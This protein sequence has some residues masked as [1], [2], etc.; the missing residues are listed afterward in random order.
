M[1]SEQTR[2]VLALILPLL[3]IVVGLLPLVGVGTSMAVVSGSSQT[4]VVPASYAFP[5]MWT[6]LFAL[7]LAYGVWQILPM[8][9]AD[10]LLSRVGWPL[11]GVFALNTLWEA[12]AQFSGRN[13]FFLVAIMLLNVVC[14]LAAFFL[15]RRGVEPSRSGRWLVLP[16]TGLMAGWLTAACFANISGA[17]RVAGIIPVEGMVAT[18]A[19]VLLLLAAGGFAAA[20]VWAAKGSVWYLGG[21]GWALVAVVVANL[22]ANQ[23]DVLAALTAAVMLALVA[24]VAWTRRTPGPRGRRFGA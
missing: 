2:R 19:A 5:I 24:G 6:V 17:A 10:P 22:G 23:L 13:G 21:V 18:V 14:A 4:P 12:V 9:H 3:Q 11:V 20:V 8:N 16:L 1:P 7:S 15:A